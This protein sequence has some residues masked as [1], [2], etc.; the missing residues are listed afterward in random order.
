MNDASDGIFALSFLNG[1]DQVGLLG[2]V[3]DVRREQAIISVTEEAVLSVG[4]RESPLLVRGQIGGAN[5]RVHVDKGDSLGLLLL[6]V[7]DL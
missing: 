1:V 5:G 7:L 2:V 6:L 4:E 3:G